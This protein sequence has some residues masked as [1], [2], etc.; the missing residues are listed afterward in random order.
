MQVLG[1]VI[2]NTYAI[3]RHA[4]GGMRST[5]ENTSKIIADHAFLEAGVRGETTALM[6]SMCAHLRRI[7]ETAARHTQLQRPHQ[8][9]SEAPRTD[10]NPT[11]STPSR[12]PHGI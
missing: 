6:E 7:L 3:P 1:T 12:P 10:S 2:Q 8:S 4:V 5:F 9:L 11:S